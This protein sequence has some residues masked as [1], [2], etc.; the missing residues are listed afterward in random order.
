M[1]R[2]TSLSRP[3]RPTPPRRRGSSARR[4]S[5]TSCS[6][7]PMTG[8]GGGGGRGA[9]M[10]RECGRWKRGWRRPSARAASNSP[11]VRYSAPPRRACWCC[12]RNLVMDDLSSALTSK[13]SVCSGS[14]SSSEAGVTCLAVSHR[15]VG[16]GR[17]DHIIVLKDGRVEAEGTLDVCWPIARKCGPCGST[18]TTRRMWMDWSERYT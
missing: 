17:A 5:R 3:G 15:R 18:P 14:V 10:E 9:V 11:A 13:R 4:S 1:T 8:G 12:H 6:G 16:A 7:C 2:A